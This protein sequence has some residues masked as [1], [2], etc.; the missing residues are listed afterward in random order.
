MKKLL[1]LLLLALPCFAQNMR[2]DAVAWGP[3]GAV[4]NATIAVCTQP[5]STANAP[6]SPLAVLCSSLSDTTC[7]SP[8]PLTADSLGNYHFYAKMS[9]GPYTVQIYGSQVA[10]PYVLTDQYLNG[11]L[12]SPSINGTPTGTGIS[13][14]TLKKG[15]GAGNYASSS[16]TYVDVDATNLSYT[17]TI[18]TGW[19]LTII[20]SAD[21]FVQTAAV[22]VQVALFDSV[23]AGVV[24][25][26]TCWPQA[27][28]GSSVN[29][30]LPYVINGDGSSHTVKLQYK[31]TN[32]SDSVAI[33]NSSTTFTPTMVFDLSPSN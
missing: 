4:P 16:T 7:T 8:N 25:E 18:P 11:S 22:N 33:A 1:F 28:G 14:K 3:R 31:T 5:A 13:T 6:C 10:T 9:A 17:V 30:T 26:R 12:T 32:A 2:F 19:K 24:L 15:N 29:A 20:A 27:A 21:V 23:A